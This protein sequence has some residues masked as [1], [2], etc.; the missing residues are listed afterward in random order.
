MSQ[1][2]KA[3]RVPAHSGDVRPC[4]DVSPGSRAS[5]RSLSDTGKL[6]CVHGLALTVSPPRLTV[7]N[8]LQ[9]SGSG[10]RI[11][12]LAAGLSS[13]IPSCVYRPPGSALALACGAAYLVRPCLPPVS[14]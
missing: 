10:R 6:S 2:R 9:S 3:F 11:A 4:A 12:L 5:S 14:K 1:R 8:L 7:P 13:G